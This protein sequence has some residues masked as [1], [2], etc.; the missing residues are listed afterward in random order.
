MADGLAPL[1]TVHSGFHARIVAARLGADGI[2]VQLTGAADGPY[3]VGATTLWV[4]AGD[5][6]EAQ[7]LLLLDEAEWVLAEAG[8]DDDED[9][10]QDGESMT[11]LAR[12]RYFGIPVPLLLAAPLV[13]MA[14]TSL[15]LRV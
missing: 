9:E 11:P 6:D 15:V 8:I 5:L 1:L 3:P 10:D 4:L 14:V 2:P 7:D 13:G 12:A